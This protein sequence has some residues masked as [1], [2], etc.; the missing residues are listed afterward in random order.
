MKKNL[1]CIVCPI[2]CR[3]EVTLDD[4]GKVVDVAGNTCKR[5]HDYAMTE[6][7]DPRRTLTTTVRLT[8]SDSDSFLPVRTSAPI[9]KPKLFEAMKKVNTLEANAPVKV[10]D[11]ICADFIEDGI[12]LIACKNIDQGDSHDN[13]KR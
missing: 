4:N 2:G 3:L 1:T 12:N 7:T 13:S 9:P 5:G 6:F 11:V 10:G 8:G